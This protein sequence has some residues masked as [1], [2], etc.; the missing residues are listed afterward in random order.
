LRYG[1]TGHLTGHQTVRSK[2]AIVPLM[3]GRPLQQ[4][5]RRS[6]L[7]KSVA[8]KQA[9]GLRLLIVVGGHGAFVAAFC[10]RAQIVLAHLNRQSSKSAAPALAQRPHSL[11]R[12]RHVL[13]R[14]S[15]HG[16]RKRFVRPE[17]PEPGKAR[18]RQ[19]IL[20]TDQRNILLEWAEREIHRT[21]KR[22]GREPGLPRGRQAR[23]RDQERPLEI[24]HLPTGRASRR[25]RGR[26]TVTAQRQS[27]LVT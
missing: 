18:E 22:L 2:Q 3:E 23:G 27:D 6:D 7:Q 9:E 25:S 15:E 14:R 10:N 24:A 19:I 26:V 4:W 12:C 17:Q 8:E 20:K 5:S 11:G 16:A 21:V 1:V 13:S